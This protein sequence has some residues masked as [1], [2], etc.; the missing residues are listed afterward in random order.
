MLVE[1]AELAVAGAEQHEF[2]MQQLDDLR[3]LAELLGEHDRPPIAAQHIAGGCARPDP[4][5]QFILGLLHGVP[6]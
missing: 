4:G 6:L 5:Q 3:L 2:L 1:E